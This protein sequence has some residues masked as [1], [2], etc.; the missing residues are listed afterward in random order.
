MS[1]LRIMVAVALAG[2]IGA[3]AA[4]G[5]GEPVTI[6]VARHAE[7]GPESPDPELTAAGSARAKALAHVL[8]DVRLSA[9]FTS[10]FKR[11]QA[12]AAPLAA[13]LGLTPLVIAAGEMDALIGRLEQLP[14]GAGALVVSHSNLVPLIVERLSG[15]K[16]GEL[17]DADYDRL[18]AVTA[19]PDGRATV[20]YLHFGVPAGGPGAKMRP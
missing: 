12:T 15:Q 4:A 18:Y 6:F 19:W 1:L 17:T 7:K 16:V 20:L 9:I 13:L 5:Q 3:S 11:T 10:E 2:G 8:G 14:P